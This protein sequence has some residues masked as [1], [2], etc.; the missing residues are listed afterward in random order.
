M[1][2]CSFASSKIVNLLPGKPFNYIIGEPFTEFASVDS[3]N[4]YAMAFVQNGGGRHGMT[5]FAHEQTAG[6]GQRGKAWHMRRSENIMLSTLLNTSWMPLSAQFSLSVAVSLG[7][8]DFFAAHAGE[9]TKIKWPNDLYWRDRKA[10]GLLIENV[11]KGN[12]WQWAVA[13]MGININQ[14]VFDSLQNAVSLKQI[15]GKTYPVIEMAKTLCACL[16]KRYK[17][18]CEPR[19]D[20]VLLE[21]YNAVLFRRKER[22][23]LKKGSQVFECVIDHVDKLGHLHVQHP[24]FESFVHGEVQWVL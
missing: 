23:R 12:I 19:Q 20:L 5:W 14:V 22:T 8:Y 16:D 21:E 11:I 7:I 3:T 18:L 1:N 17:Q 9:E 15:T 6:K 13:G 4:N 10:V 24:V 2:N